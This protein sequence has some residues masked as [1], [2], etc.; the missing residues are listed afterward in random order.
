M[1]DWPISLQHEWCTFYDAPL[2]ARAELRVHEDHCAEIL[3]EHQDHN[4]TRVYWSYCS[5]FN[6]VAM[7]GVVGAV[8]E[9]PLRG[10]LFAA[11]PRC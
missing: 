11:T 9:P 10:V 3:E 6:K 2:P 8:R 1:L 4:P 7:P 5:P